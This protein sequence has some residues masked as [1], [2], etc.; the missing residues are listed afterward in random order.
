MAESSITLFPGRVTTVSTGMA[1]GTTIYNG[2]PANAVWISANP[3]PGP[4]TGGVRIGPKGSVSWT[5]DGAAVYGAVDTGVTAAVTL[6]LSPNISNPVNPIDVGV[7]VALQLLTTG[8]PLTFTS[9]AIYGSAGTGLIDVTKYGSMSFTFYSTVPQ[10]WTILHCDAIG[11]VLDTS[12]YVT[13]VGSVPL[14]VSLPVRG[15]KI[16]VNSTSALGNPIYTLYGS[17]RLLPEAVRAPRDPFTSGI[18]A[19]FTSGTR[20]NFPDTFTSPGGQFYLRTNVGSTTLNGFIGINYL[21]T[22]GAAIH[23]ELVDTK[24]GIVG[25]SNQEI[26][27][28]IQLPP[29]V[30]TLYFLPAATQTS[31]ITVTLIPA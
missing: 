14:T 6:V 13:Q 31:G 16:Q 28:L 8:V 1:A 29:G 4:N 12:T 23:L 19:S 20:A 9:S 24:T 26:E 15:A 17:S 22:S 3:T 21:D 27:Q 5:T 10:R 30:Y 7:A 18:S 25:S 11:N 2:D